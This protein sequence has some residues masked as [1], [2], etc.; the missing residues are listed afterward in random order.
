MF[1]TS[2]YVYYCLI[3]AS[4]DL[5]GSIAFTVS[6]ISLHWCGLLRHNQVPMYKNVLLTQFETIVYEVNRELEPGCECKYNLKTN[7]MIRAEPGKLFWFFELRM[8]ERTFCFLK[9]VFAKGVSAEE[10]GTNEF[11]DSTVLPCCFSITFYSLAILK[12]M[13]TS[14]ARKLV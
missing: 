9:S 13:I 8:C 11:R 7:K 12:K 14:E 4:A 6:K 10:L 5:H 2:W 1:F 3:A